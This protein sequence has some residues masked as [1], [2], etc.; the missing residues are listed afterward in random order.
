V[1]PDNIPKWDLQWSDDHQWLAYMGW[2]SSEPGVK[3][4]SL[5]VVDGDGKSVKKLAGPNRS[6]FYDWDDVNHIRIGVADTL[7]KGGP[8]ER[9]WFRVDVET[10]VGTRIEVERTIPPPLPEPRLIEA[11]NGQWIVQSKAEGSK[12]AFYL[13][14][15]NE[16][17]L[18]LIYEQP[19]DLGKEFTMWSKNSQWF[20]YSPLNEDRYYADLY[21]YHPATLSSRRLTTFEEQ[22]WFWIGGFEWSPNGDWLLFALD[23]PVKANQLCVIDF[24]RDPDVRCF[25]VGYKSSQ[26]VWSSDSRFVAFLAGGLETTDIYILE[27]SGGKVTN[28]TNDGASEIE[29]QITAN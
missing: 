17:Q 12:R 4:G 19:S 6:I 9:D 24:D 10:G 28:L 21:L 26:H 22:G 2:E 25:D 8:Q 3:M 1:T 20:I 13:L 23:G 11:P 16:N 14:D 27:V 29:D 7:T 18:A 15:K 5:F